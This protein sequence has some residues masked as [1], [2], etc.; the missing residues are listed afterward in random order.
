MS[1]IVQIK[2][3]NDILDQLFDF[4]EDNFQMFKSDIILSRSTIQFMRKSN[5][6]LVVEQF[7]N[8][9]VQYKREIFDCNEDFFL[10]I[11]NFGL[12]GE[13]AVFGKKLRS[14]WRS[15]EI[16]NEQKAY[17]WLYF[18]KLYRAGERVTQ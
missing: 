11:E 18:Q 14:I 8:S 6:R 16:T 7:M 12:S 15:S 4:L 5:P 2:I 13:N 1:K 3:F 17:I 10:N 9:A